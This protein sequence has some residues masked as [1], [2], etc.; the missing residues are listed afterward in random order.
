[1]L[2]VAEPVGGQAVRPGAALPGAVQVMAPQAAPGLDTERIVLV[3]PDRRMSHFAAS[4]WPAD[5]PVVV[6]ALAVDALRTSGAFG[7]VLDSRSPFPADYVLELTVRGFEAD[8]TAQGATP[9]VRVVLDG[10]L[11]HREGRGVLANFTV[12]GLAPAR[13]N[14]MGEVVA[15]FEDAANQALTEL[16][17]RTA[18]AVEAAQAAS[19]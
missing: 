17:A 9:T 1:V 11:G 7:V 19:R 5:L 6:E 4:R 15:A 3:N 10:I 8:Y 12:T 16:V 14:R 13:A 18:A 2:R